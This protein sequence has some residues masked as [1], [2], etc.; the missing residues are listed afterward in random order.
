MHPRKENYLK[1]GDK[2]LK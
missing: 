2:F 1:I